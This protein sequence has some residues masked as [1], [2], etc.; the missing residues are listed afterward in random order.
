MADMW[1]RK[2]VLN[3]GPEE[4]V[5]PGT[6]TEFELF[7]DRANN[8]GFYGMK[9]LTGG[10]DRRW[11]NCRFV[12]RGRDQLVWPKHM[13]LMPWPANPSVDFRTKYEDSIETVM[14]KYTSAH[15]IRLEAD[16]ETGILPRL[17][18]K[19]ANLL[20]GIDAIEDAGGK[21]LP[22]ILVNVSARLFGR[23]GPIDDGTAHG[24]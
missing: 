24:N 18:L 20:I 7:A 16:I 22:L 1:E 5:Q 21:L 13:R 4:I 14:R 3:D 23:G 15:T 6:K 2:W 9:L 12:L 10:A 8:C 17:R 19:R 11:E